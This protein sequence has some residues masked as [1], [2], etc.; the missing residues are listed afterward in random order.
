MLRYLTIIIFLAI[1]LI[2]LL[3]RRLHLFFRLTTFIAIIAGVLIMVDEWKWGAIWHWGKWFDPTYSFNNDWTILFPLFIPLLTLAF[4]FFIKSN[5][6][7][8][9]FSVINTVTALLL[10]FYAILPVT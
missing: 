7:L 9:V 6:W 8:F 10:T 4:S 1:G 5:R 3:T 2:Q